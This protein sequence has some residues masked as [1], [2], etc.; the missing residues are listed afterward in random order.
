MGIDLD[1]LGWIGAE[2]EDPLLARQARFDFANYGIDGSGVA[3]SRVP[4]SGDPHITVIEPSAYIDT[5][6][7]D[8]L[9]SSAFPTWLL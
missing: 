7:R 8:L 1:G 9:E 3:T 5:Q 6:I 2:D 4:S